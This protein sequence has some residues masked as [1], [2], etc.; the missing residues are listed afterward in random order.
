[1]LLILCDGDLLLFS[2]LLVVL[3]SVLLSSLVLVL[4]VLI[5]VFFRDM[6]RVR[7]LFREF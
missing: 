3:F 7:N 2:S 6:V 4:L 1:M 5:L